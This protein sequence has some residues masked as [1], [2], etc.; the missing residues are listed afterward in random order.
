MT[1][2][3]L[4]FYYCITATPPKYVCGLNKLRGHHFVSPDVKIMFFIFTVT[5]FRA[6]FRVYFVSSV[7]AGT[8]NIYF[9][10]VLH[11]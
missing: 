9:S 1:K 2:T 5:K 3:L 11:M 10:C 4:L 8:K 7:K 6:T